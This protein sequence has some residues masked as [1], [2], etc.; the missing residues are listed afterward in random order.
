MKARPLQTLMLVAGAS[1][2]FCASGPSFDHFN[3]GDPTYRAEADESVSSESHNPSREQEFEIQAK[4]LVV[5][6]SVPNSDQEGA[7]FAPGEGEVDAKITQKFTAKEKVH[8]KAPEVHIEAGNAVQARAKTQ[9]KISSD[10]TASREQETEARIEASPIDLKLEGNRE[11]RF[12]DT[13]PE[14]L[15]CDFSA[16]R[17]MEYDSAQLKKSESHFYL[18]A[19]PQ[20]KVATDQEVTA[21][22]FPSDEL[23]SS[24]KMSAAI[25]SL[26]TIATTT[27]EI[28]V[29]LFEE[30]LFAPP[31]HV[32]VSPHG[33]AELEQWLHNPNL[34]PDNVRI[35]VQIDS[36]ELSKVRPQDEASQAPSVV[37]KWKG[38]EDLPVDSSAPYFDGKIDSS[39]VGTIAKHEPFVEVF[40]S[41]GERVIMPVHIFAQLPGVTVHKIEQITAP[42]NAATPK[43]EEY[44]RVTLEVDPVV[45][46]LLA[47]E[48]EWNVGKYL[49]EAA[50]DPLLPESR[51]RAHDKGA[52]SCAKSIRES[53]INPEFY[54]RASKAEELMPTERI[55]PHQVDQ[56]TIQVE[57]DP[58]SLESIATQC[59]WQLSE[60]MASTP[61][62]S[63][64]I[65]KQSEMNFVKKE[66]TCQ[67]LSS[68]TNLMQPLSVNP[69]LDAGPNAQNALAESSALRVYFSSFDI[70]LETTK[71]E[72]PLFTPLSV[73]FHALS[74][75]TAVT[76]GHKILLDP[77]SE[78][79]FT[80][81]VSAIPH[82]APIQFSD[83]ALNFESNDRISQFL[84]SEDSLSAFTRLIWEDQQQTFN[85]EEE[86]AEN[87][88]I[89][90]DYFREVPEFDASTI[91]QANFFAALNLPEIC[92]EQKSHI[93]PTLIDF[94][95]VPY[96]R[97][98]LAL[99]E[100]ED[101][102]RPEYAQVIDPF[103]QAD[104][105]DLYN[106]KALP[107]HPYRR[108]DYR[109]LGA[110]TRLIAKRPPVDIKV[111]PRPT[112]S[113]TS[114]LELTRL[115]RSTRLAEYNLSRIP[116]LD[117]L[118]TVC[119]HYDY[120]TRVE[121]ATKPDGI[122][123]YFSVGL[124]PIAPEKLN[125]VRQN[126][127]FVVD[128]N[129]YITKERYATFRKGI[130]KALR[131]LGPNDTFN[132]LVCDK[133]VYA[134]SDH[135]V[136]YTD[137]TEQQ[138]FEFLKSQPYRR[139]MRSLTITEILSS[140]HQLFPNED[141]V[142]TVILMT[143]GSSIF[144]KQ[145]KGKK[146]IERG[147]D[148]NRGDYSL[149]TI[150]TGPNNNVRSLE[151]LAKTFRG[152][153]VYHKSQQAFPRLLA[154][155]V[156]DLREPL[157]KSVRVTPINREN[158]NV[159]IY[160]GKER[161]ADMYANKPLM[162]YGSADTLGEF[163]LMI[164]GKV[165]EEWINIKK[166][167]RLSGAPMVGA[168]LRKVCT[169][170]D[171][172]SLHISKL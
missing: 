93:D 125:N 111:L 70:A 3:L 141:E 12:L 56:Q 40:T 94:G 172:E 25:D 127:L 28:R 108:I 103:V 156:R 27:P 104:T 153:A 147:L 9:E 86:I 89:V 59:G 75:M 130:M 128:K 98:H 78:Y 57:I 118:S 19:T 39:F 31:E 143:N 50:T 54:A 102:L 46:N 72:K 34:K 114:Q 60:F 51:R 41:T 85:F 115:N 32:Q 96:S 90:D 4:E 107:R 100:L 92:I 159:K 162:I 37:A 61:T 7:D 74:Q 24:P 88:V 150:A 113:P 63:L 65:A 170:L 52:I 135:G 119:Y 148:K 131:Y 146:R 14:A 84:Q 122:G 97:E 158:A 79:E 83:H 140:L 151:K 15:P 161:L 144:S 124:Y 142:N 80:H 95:L 123:F 30:T 21:S 167:I 171:T 36:S 23:A 160:G 26:S 121:V 2:A 120:K 68:V 62:N 33:K 44:S 138:A 81:L 133:T 42:A 154:R 38:P 17:S 149:F 48:F 129:S 6:F 49:E 11:I 1:S 166:C 64:E 16:D 145:T 20:A 112:E 87:T 134:M 43:E 109:S 71:Y 117:E 137:Q 169:S 58:L 76:S 136:N 22:V 101:D 67:G 165:G 55:N 155:L 77:A 73:D 163:D 8:L 164:Q 116:T 35:L 5:E 126:F 157:A 69:E 10:T 152:E 82:S 99:D 45:L 66:L 105:D 106:V 91:S 132:V 53:E 47:S 110:K 18:S 139:I 29:E 13:S 168:K